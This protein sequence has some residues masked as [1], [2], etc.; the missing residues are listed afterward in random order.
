MPIYYS[1]LEQPL[2][3]AGRA[4]WPG[5]GRSRG[6]NRV[7]SQATAFRPCQYSKWATCPGAPMCKRSAIQASV[8]VVSLRR[9]AAMSTFCT[10]PLRRR[11]MP[12]GQR[13]PKRPHH[14]HRPQHRPGHRSLTRGPTSP[15]RHFPGAVAVP[16]LRGQS[17]LAATTCFQPGRFPGITPRNTE[18]VPQTLPAYCRVRSVRAA[19]ALGVPPMWI[20][21]LSG[22]AALAAWLLPPAFRLFPSPSPAPAAPA[23]SPNQSAR[24]RS[25]SQRN[26][27]APS[28]DPIGPV[29]D[30][31]APSAPFCATSYAALPSTTRSRSTSSRPRPKPP[32]SAVA[33]ACADPGE[34]NT[35][36]ATVYCPSYNKPSRRTGHSSPG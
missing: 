12:L 27:S 7:F 23:A 24:S 34:R 3:G 33:R 5:A 31:S 8:I 17:R 32:A 20:A 36:A 18:K 15:S 21:Q 25:S 10:S 26:T 14:P 6:Q 1:I 2:V 22:I 13:A 35:C 29:A 28:A 9:R 30:G 11:S 16:R 19:C 4:H